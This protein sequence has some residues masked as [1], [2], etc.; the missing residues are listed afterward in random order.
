MKIKILMSVLALATLS[1]K[2]P[3]DTGTLKELTTQ[4][5]ELQAENKVLKDSLSDHQEQFLRS[6]ILLGISDDCVLTVGK[7]NK[8]AMIFHPYGLTIPQYDIYKLENGKEIKIGSN[9]KTR[10]DYDFTPKSV[11]DNELRLKVKLKYKDKIIEY[12]A[13]MIFKVK[14]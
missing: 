4:I 14:K 3:E 8:V 13:G 12:P 7:K 1:C 9:T 6:Q 5:E 11:E 2:Q 10:F